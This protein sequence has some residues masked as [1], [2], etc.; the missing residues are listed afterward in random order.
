MNFY[1][2]LSRGSVYYWILFRPITAND[3]HKKQ[4]INNKKKKQ[5]YLLPISSISRPS[6]LSFGFDVN[7]SQGTKP[8]SM[9]MA[10]TVENIF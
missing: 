10:R 3:Y 8:M 1:A 5:I 2:V 9:F 4:K 6:L 7:Q